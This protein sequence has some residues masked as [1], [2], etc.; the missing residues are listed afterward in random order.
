MSG[1]HAEILSEDIEFF[2]S[3]SG[4][5]NGVAMAVRGDRELKAGQR[6]LLGDQI[7]RVENV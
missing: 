7:L 5:R 2:V 1:R 3:D 6:F 4:S